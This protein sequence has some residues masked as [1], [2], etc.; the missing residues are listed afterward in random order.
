MMLE[1]VEELCVYNEHD[2]YNGHVATKQ[3]P[4]SSILI[5]ATV[6]PTD[7]PTRTTTPKHD[8]SDDA[9]FTAWTCW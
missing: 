8:G 2:V 5:W 9:D 3:R 7:H 6:R 1:C 4:L